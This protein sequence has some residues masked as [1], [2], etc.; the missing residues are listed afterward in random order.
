MGAPASRKE[1]S[2][3][4][5]SRE[6]VPQEDVSRQDMS[7]QGIVRAVWALTATV[8][9]LACV[10]ITVLLKA[11]SYDMHLGP[12]HLVAHQLFKPFLLL[13]AAFWVAV[14]VRGLLPQRPQPIGAPGRR[15]ALSAVALVLAVYAAIYLPS[16]GINVA[17]PGWIVSEVTSP[18][19][20]LP[21]AVFSLFTSPQ[22]DGFYRPL[23]LVSLWV[24]FRLFGAALWGYHLQNI[25]VHVINSILVYKL[26]RELRF[27]GTAG[28]WS[29]AWFLLASANF[30]PILWPGARFDLFATAFVL[31][32]LIGFL[33][34]L[35]T[36]G[37]AL[38][39]LSTAAGAYALA[40]LNKESAYCVPLVLAMLVFTKGAWQ[41]GS[42]D[43][44]KLWRSASVFAV[45]TAFMLA[46]R[47][48]IYGGLGGYPSL[49]Q[50]GASPHFSLTV[51]S[52]LGILTRVIPIPLLGL[53]LSVPL[54]AAMAGFVLLYLAAIAWA[55]VRGA[56]A[57]K[58][59]R[60]LVCLALLSAL[61]AVNLTGWIDESMRY[62]RYLYL[63]GLFILMAAATL[64][65]RRPF[66]KV[67]L[68]AL[69]AANAAGCVHN[70]GVYRSVIAEAHAISQQVAEDC[71][72]YHAAV[73][74]LTGIESYPFG[75]L[76]FRS[77]IAA[78]LH[79][80][81]PGVC[82]NI[83]SAAC[84]AGQ[85]A[86]RYDWTRGAGA[87]ANYFPQGLP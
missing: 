67:A 45:I 41:L 31:I 38:A 23:T 44:V 64:L 21:G 13:G 79:A 29:A 35:R 8:F 57:A 18:L 80:A 6:K 52:F 54:S 73:V 62:S 51:K 47:V 50:G 58:P 87:K 70:L 81:Q 16:A 82:I 27:E 85:P 65:A 63:P 56:S 22:T 42:M 39:A 68:A 9:C 10:N 28:F 25:L 48:A 1:V 83:S 33:R 15:T 78:Q 71:A 75:V 26:A 66:G 19:R 59:Q 84:A 77:E 36:P 86:L 49:L 30:E 69:V 20:S 2:R 5:V 32:S 12:L 17:D 14:L 74:D 53:N 43:R 40:L 61:P 60:V 4:D 76:F 24:D 34:H 37:T 3:K 11:P 46:I 72:Q 7:R 55:V